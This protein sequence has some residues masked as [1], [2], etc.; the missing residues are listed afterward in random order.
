MRPLELGELAEV[1]AINPQGDP[2][3]DHDARFQ[4]PRDI[5]T[6]CQG[7]VVEE[8]RDEDDKSVDDEDD[9][10]ADDENDE[11]ADDEDDDADKD[12]DDSGDHDAENDADWTVDDGEKW[13]ENN[14]IRDEDHDEDQDED[15]SEDRNVGWVD[16]SDDS[17]EYGNNGDDGDNIGDEENSKYA[18]NDESSDQIDDDGSQI[19]GCEDLSAVDGS[20]DSEI[21]PY[22]KNGFKNR[23]IVR[24]AHFSVKEYLLSGR[25]RKKSTSC[26]AEEASKYAIQEIS[27]HES[28]VAHCLAYLL[29]F[30]RDEKV[31]WSNGI[32]YR[33]FIKDYHLSSYAAT[34]WINHVKVLGKNLRST[35]QLCS[36]LFF[37][38]KKAFQNSK[39]LDEHCLPG[40]P[41]LIASEKGA[42]ELV[43][44][45]LE[46]GADV[47]TQTE[48]NPSA[49]LV[50]SKNGHLE[51]VRLLLENG[52][53]VNAQDESGD[54]H[55]ALQAASYKGHVEIMQLLLTHGAEVNAQGGEYHTALHAAAMK[56]HEEVIKVLLSEKADV[57]ISGQFS[58]IW[59]KGGRGTALH[60]ASAWAQPVSIRLLL[61]Y[62]ADVNAKGIFDGREMTALEL[63]EQG[64][65][66][67]LWGDTYLRCSDDE[68]EKVVSL[69]R[70]AQDSQRNVEVSQ[71]SEDTV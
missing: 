66:D 33:R 7:L 26:Y 19:T 2:W 4:E 1:V 20:S 31:Y 29:Q 28:I 5:L 49:L 11:S 41:L 71:V 40:T 21:I 64:G 70:S 52:A 25:I 53:D 15:R 60:A 56:G 45:V 17:E 43:R 36:M 34:Q 37:E 46:N 27:A 14:E 68:Y 62:G 47:N 51:T 39:V 58:D 69:L 9:K 8:E 32:S 38:H 63:A 10:S 12:E 24:L 67:E 65:I 6:I 50:A 55:T 61:E 30:E 13:D 23:N 35:K 57:S 59:H 44:L 18:N 16:T 3:F 48:S 54:F 22:A 42:I